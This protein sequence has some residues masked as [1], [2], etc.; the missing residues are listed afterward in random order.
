M[1][2]GCQGLCYKEKPAD[3]IKYSEGWKRCSVCGK[4]IKTDDV[5]CYCCR[6]PLRTKVRVS[7]YKGELLRI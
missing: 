4:K 1:V 6:Y 7:K 3:G 5:R 2:G